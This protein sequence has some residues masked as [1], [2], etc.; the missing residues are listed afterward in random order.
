MIDVFEE[1]R[2]KGEGQFRASGVQA[3]Q[4]SGK[5]EKQRR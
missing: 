5:M 3:T 2:E 4:D 1:G